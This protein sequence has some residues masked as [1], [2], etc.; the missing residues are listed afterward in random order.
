MTGELIFTYAKPLQ[1]EDGL[2]LLQRAV[3]GVHDAAAE[4]SALLLQ[5]RKKGRKI[6]FVPL[7]SVM[8]H[9]GATAGATLHTQTSNKSEA[10]S[11]T[12]SNNLEDCQ[13]VVGRRPHV[14]EHWQPR[15]ARQVELALE[16]LLLH[17]RRTELQPA[18]I[19]SQPTKEGQRAR[20][21]V[22]KYGWIILESMHSGITLDPVGGRST[23]WLR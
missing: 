1:A 8:A 17:L 20:C 3:E 7:S 6:T 11:R 12:W 10:K 4:E 22:C 23:V 9:A 13:H 19:A 5:G 14:Q 2:S 16:P 15:V 21:C 18:R